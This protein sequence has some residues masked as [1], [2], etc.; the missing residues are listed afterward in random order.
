MLICCRR[1]SATSL[2]I[3]TTSPNANYVENRYF[4][5]SL[6]VAPSGILKSP[7]IKHAILSFMCMHTSGKMLRNLSPA[8]R[9]SSTDTSR[10]LLTGNITYGFRSDNG[11]QSSITFHTIHSILTLCSSTKADFSF[12]SC[13]RRR[14]RCLLLRTNTFGGLQSQTSSHQNARI[15]FSSTLKSSTSF[16][17]GQYSQSMQTWWLPS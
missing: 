12:S 11:R 8:R 9:V 6:Y 5:L 10:A 7:P 17:L 2:A 13:L 4:S 15:G 3:L 14:I 16:R 1:C